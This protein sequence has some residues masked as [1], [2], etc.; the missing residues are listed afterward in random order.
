M[1]AVLKSEPHGRYAHCIEVSK[2]IR[3]EIERDVFKGRRF[4]FGKGNYILGG[5]QFAA[6]HNYKSGNPIQIFENLA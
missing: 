2:R 6:I 4:D 5:W 1:N 3:W